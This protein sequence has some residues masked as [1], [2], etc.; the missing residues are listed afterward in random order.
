[1]YAI[2]E[3]AGKQYKVEK[4]AVVNVDRLKKTDSNITLDKVLLYSNDSDVRVGT[5]YLTNVQIKAEVLGEIK[6][7]KVSGVKFKKRKNYTRTIGHRAIY[8]QIK[9]SDVTAN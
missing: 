1:M 6:G 7:N 8:S 3:I 2:V 5:P 4:D 9:I